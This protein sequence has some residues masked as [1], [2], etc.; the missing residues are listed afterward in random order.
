MVR[1]GVI[2]VVTA[3]LGC[4]LTGCLAIYSKRPVEVVVTDADTGQ[5]VADLPVIVDYFKLTLEYPAVGPLNVPEGVRG[6][7]DANGRVV[8]PIADFGHGSIRLQAGSYGSSI[9]PETVR[10]GGTVTTNDWSLLGILAPEPRA[11][12]TQKVVLQLIPQRRSFAHR[13]FGSRE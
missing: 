12:K 11:T 5:P 4:S 10:K 13:L 2:T 6:V 7:T 1:S 8:L 3:A 9:E